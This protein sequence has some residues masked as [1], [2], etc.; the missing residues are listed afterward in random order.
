[1]NWSLL[2]P[3]LVTTTLAIFGWFIAHRLAAARD[4]QNKRRE[5]RATILIEA[6]QALEFSAHRIYNTETSPPIE[7]ALAN[8]Q[9]LGTAKQVMIAKEMIECFAA[10]GSID[11]MP[12]L[13]DLRDDLRTELGLETVPREF[14]HL[15]C[16]ET[17]VKQ[18]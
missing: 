12:L 17:N 18:A 16:P 11:W 6:F 8:V 15:R 10:D 14:R 3:L 9:L 7:K 13:L 1:M 2:I 5:M 4:R